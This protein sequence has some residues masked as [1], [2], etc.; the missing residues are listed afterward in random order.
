[1]IVKTTGTNETE[2]YSRDEARVIE[3]KEPSPATVKYRPL[4]RLIINLYDERRGK[5]HLYVINVVDRI[6][7]FFY[8]IQIQ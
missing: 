6:S 2:K 5:I 4:P 8:L 1:M 3:N 7:F